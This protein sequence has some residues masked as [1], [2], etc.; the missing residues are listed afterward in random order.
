MCAMPLVCSFAENCCE[1]SDTFFCE[2]CHLVWPCAGAILE[3]PPVGNSLRSGIVLVCESK[4][5][6]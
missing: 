5:K 2:N 4:A 6:S 3:A 1:S